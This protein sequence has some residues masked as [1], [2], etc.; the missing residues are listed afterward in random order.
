MSYRE[1][2]SLHVR[3]GEMRILAGTLKALEKEKTKIEDGNKKTKR[4]ASWESRSEQSSTKR[5]RK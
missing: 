1:K 2:I 5:F 4:T 3:L